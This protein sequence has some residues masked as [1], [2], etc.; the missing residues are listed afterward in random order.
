MGAS[1]DSAGPKAARS[2]T[3]FV[4][5]LTRITW[6]LSS[7]TPRARQAPNDKEKMIVTAPVH[8]PT[9]SGTR[10][11]G[12]KPT[13]PRARGPHHQRRSI[14]P[15]RRMT[16]P[17]PR[18]RASATRGPKEPQGDQA[19][20]RSANSS[21]RR[22]AQAMCR[23]CGQTWSGSRTAHCGDIRGCHKTFGGIVAADMHFRGMDPVRHLHP[24]DVG[25]R[26]DEH[27]VWRRRGPGSK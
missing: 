22:D 7:P 13:S 2:R 10:E 8:R 1:E 18:G 12:R 26:Q 11:G 25:L 3:F 14:D 17:C 24:A 21:E 6:L 19:P 23:M 27:G 4:R 15:H 9:E 20:T 5:S 16:L